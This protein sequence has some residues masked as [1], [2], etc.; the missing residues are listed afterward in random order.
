ME[1]FGTDFICS[2]IQDLTAVDL[3]SDDLIGRISSNFSGLAR[4]Q[5]DR[6]QNWNRDWKLN[7]QI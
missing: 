1:H 7:Y 2:E 5:L 6:I 4:S 3:L